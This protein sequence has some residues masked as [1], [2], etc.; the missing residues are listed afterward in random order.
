[1]NHY[2]GSAEPAVGGGGE[3]PPRVRGKRQRECETQKFAAG[4][5]GTQDSGVVEGDDF[6]VFGGISVRVCC[7]RGGGGCRGRRGR[8]GRPGQQR[9]AS[10]GGAGGG[11][12]RC[13]A[14]PMFWTHIR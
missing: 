1:V 14:L 6:R 5:G 10:G 4:A 11:R 3:R 7:V 12:R 2:G 9:G 8:G 13:H